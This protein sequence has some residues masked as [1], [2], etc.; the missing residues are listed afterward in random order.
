MVKN[1]MYAKASTLGQGI[2]V[3]DIKKSINFVFKCIKNWVSWLIKYFYS[4]K[5]PY[6]IINVIVY[7]CPIFCI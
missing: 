6:V 5:I 4:N 3:V 7:T 2:S 1:D